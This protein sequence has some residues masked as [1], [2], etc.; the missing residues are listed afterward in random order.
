MGPMGQ[1]GQMKGQTKA[2]VLP[3]ALRSISFRKPVIGNRVYFTIL[4]SCDRLYVL[5]A[6]VSMTFTFSV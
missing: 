6:A 5:L 3:P 2:P 1:M 4:K